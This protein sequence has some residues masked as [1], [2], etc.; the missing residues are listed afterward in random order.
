MAQPNKGNRRA[1]IIVTDLEVRR[2]IHSLATDA[3][4]SVSVYVANH[5]ARHVGRPD[6]VEAP[7]P[8]FRATIFDPNVKTVTIRCHKDI[9]QELVKKAARAGYQAPAT[10]VIDF[11]TELAKSGGAATE[12]N[13]AYQE[14]LLTSA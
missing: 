11:V 6:L 2:E 10:Y 3:K 9:H 4:L 14:E 1:Y 13:Y 12:I 7:S 5:L 8:R